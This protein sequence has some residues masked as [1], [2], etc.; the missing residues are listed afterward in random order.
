MKFKFI[1][2][3]IAVLCS[4]TTFA[5]ITVKG[6]VTDKDSLPVPGANIA[7]KGTGTAVSTDFDGKYSIVVPNKEAQLQFTF[8]GFTTK[9]VTVGERTVVDVVLEQTS[10]VLDEVVVVG[11]ATVKKKDVT[12]SIAS[13]KGKELQTMT[14][15]NATE[16]L[17]GKVAG[18]QITGAGGPGAQPRVL[19]RGIS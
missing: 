7:V 19:I 4:A 9:I 16:S 2:L 1:W 3:F 13:V 15:G 14:V 12:S 5:Q 8:T 18:V 17:Q 11:Y 10:Q 6:T